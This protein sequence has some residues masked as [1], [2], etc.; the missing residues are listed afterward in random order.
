MA[1]ELRRLPIPVHKIGL[2]GV[3][4]AE[5]EGFVHENSPHGVR[6]AEN[7]GFVHENGTSGV[8]EGTGDTKPRDRGHEARNRDE[9]KG[10]PEGQPYR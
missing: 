9:K 6:E 7:E 5:N 3:R 4:E 8:R 1:V 10:R 2:Y